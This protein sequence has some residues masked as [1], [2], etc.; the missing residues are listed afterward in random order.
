M[1]VAAFLVSML[2]PLIDA[3]GRPFGGFACPGSATYRA[4]LT[5]WLAFVG[6]LLATRERPAPDAVHRGGDRARAACATGRGL[7]A[8]SI[9]AA[10]CAVLAYS[11][12]GVVAAD[13][14]QGTMLAIGIPA[15]VSECVMPLALAL[16]ALRLAWGAG[17]SWKGRAVAF[18]AIA[19]AFALG[20]DS[21]RG[22]R[23]VGAAARAGDPGDARRLAGVPR[24][25]RRR[26]GAVLQGRGA[27]SPRSPRRSTGSWCR[28]RC[29]RSRCSP[30]A[31]TC[32]RS[33][34]PRT[35]WCASSA[36]CSAGCPAAWPCWWWRC[37]RCSP[38]S[39]AARAS[40]SWRSA[41]CCSPS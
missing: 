7:F 6:G 25:G 29:R 31:A 23:A 15:W 35:G 12:V 26:A 19:A 3:L 36:P 9:A 14:T 17:E 30:P 39:R 13:R 10:I 28:R 24:H 16:I 18:A 8:S 20:R 2:L 38:R 32:S 22:P 41:D 1:L 37:A 5:L 33:P 11:A 34:T 21:R 27:R 40:R 4:Q